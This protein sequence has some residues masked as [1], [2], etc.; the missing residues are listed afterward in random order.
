VIIMVLRNVSLLV[1]VG[2]ECWWLGAMVHIPSRCWLN[3][4]ILSH[5][6]A[7]KVTIA[8]TVMAVAYY[9]DCPPND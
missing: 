2:V 4:L 6:Y 9:F 1:K 5:G 8:G 3:K 7:G